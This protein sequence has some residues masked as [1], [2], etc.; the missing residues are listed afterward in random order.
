MNNFNLLN[1]E[2]E[3]YNLLHRQS[4]FEESQ[5]GYGR[6]VGLLVNSELYFYKFWR[7][8]NKDKD[9]IILDIGLGAGETIK[10]FQN[11]KYDFYGIDISDYVVSELTNLLKTDRL[12][13]CSA[14]DIKLPSKFCD[15][16]QHLDGFEHIPQEIE[17]ECLKESIRIS[18]GYVFHAIACTDAYWDHFLNQNGYDNAHINIK[19]PSEWLSFFEKYSKQLNY[20]IFYNET[21]G[22]TIYIILKVK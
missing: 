9:K 1:K 6:Q 7:E 16:V 11:N 4:G 20:E 3:K 22:E 13:C 21:I 14:H 12:I 10:Y 19:T 17:I 2:R 8:I 18:K 5:Q 15:V